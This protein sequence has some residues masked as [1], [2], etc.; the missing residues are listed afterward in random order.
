[1]GK[2]VEWV[3]DAP[4]L[5]LGRIVAQIVNE[6]HFAVGQGVAAAE[7]VDI[8]MRLG[9]NWPRGPF[10]WAEAIG[11][12]RVVSVLDELRS[13]LGAERY[14]VA[15]LLRRAA[16]ESRSLDRQ[17]GAG[18][19]QRQAG[20]RG[21]GDLLA[22]QDGAIGD[23][24]PR[25]QVGDDER[26]C[27]PHPPDQGVEDREREP[28][29]DHPQRR[30]RRQRAQGGTDPGAVA[31]AAGSSQIVLATITQAAIPIGGAPLSRCLTRKPPTAY[32]RP[33]STIAR[34]PSD[35]PSRT[36]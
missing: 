11:P 3:G 4:G 12:A 2:H 17:P 5:V 14:R 22:E 32:P 18:Q 7:D 25:R 24:E 36:R 31:S 19:D 29:S 8:A 6:A 21:D 35:R 13:E 34:P 15:P 16:R 9:F 1:M 26:A 27:G 33:A 23:R 28:G 30:D 10:E 20:E